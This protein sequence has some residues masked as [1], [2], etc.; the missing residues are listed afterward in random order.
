[1]VFFAQVAQAAIINVTGANYVVT[2]LY[3]E[4]KAIGVDLVQNGPEKIRTEIRINKDAKCYRV[5][6]GGGK[7]T[8]LTVDAFYNSLHKGSRVRVNGGRDWDGKINAS[9]LWVQE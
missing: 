5:H 2:K 8:P 1:M 9:D 7:D 6:P 4:R 3:R